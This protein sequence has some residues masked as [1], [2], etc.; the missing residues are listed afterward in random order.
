MTRP[1]FPV[2]V[3]IVA[4]VLAGRLVAFGA[5]VVF[6]HDGFGILEDLAK[7]DLTE[8]AAAELLVTP[9]A[10]AGVTI[11]DWSIL[12]TGAH[13]CRTRHR[14]LFD[15]AMEERIVAEM[16]DFSDKAKWCDRQAIA[17][18]IAHY[19]SGPLD[20]LDIVVKHGHARGLKVYGNVRLNHA[21]ATV[22]L[23]G[24]PGRQFGAGGGRRMD[25]SDPVFHD[26]LIEVYED[27]LAKGV[28]GLSLD[29]ERKAPFFPDTVPQAE[30][31]DACRR[32]LR[33]VR[34]LTDKP[35]IARVAHDPAKG[36]PQGQD[37]EAWIREGLLDAVVPATHNHEP[38]DLA[39]TFE[40]F[41]EAARASPR[42][43]HVWPQ[44]WP[45][46]E[47]WKNP[48]PPRFPLERF[49]ARSRDIVAAGGDGVYFFNYRCYWPR[50]GV[51]EPDTAAMFTAIGG[52]ATR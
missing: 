52:I 45:T 24:V 27:L 15:P 26:Y 36:G 30:R 40:R 35:I 5:E 47:A 33:R 21:N 8:R 29:F 28:D 9:L 17:R 11:I 22:M 48:P 18:V 25:F 20:L 1:A 38:E 19:A 7:T 44:I 49:V 32:F 50:L 14:R 34:A 43:C 3:A 31:T 23:E 37:P 51:A 4:T 41:V 42:A 13:N 6:N 39:W 46:S 2:F 12:S 16:P 10:D